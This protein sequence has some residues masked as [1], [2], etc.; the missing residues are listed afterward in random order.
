ML[1]GISVRSPCLW[2]ALVASFLLAAPLSAAEW[3]KAPDFETTKEIEGQKVRFAFK[4]EYLA[5][6][7]VDGKV[8]LDVRSD[9]GLQDFQ[10]K[11]PAILTALAERKSKGCGV[12]I[13]LPSLSPVV[14]DA[15]S[16]RIDGKVRVELRQKLL[17]K[18]KKLTRE[19]ADLVVTARPLVG[20]DHIRFEATV[21]DLNLGKS[22][23]EGMEDEVRELAQDALSK[24]ISDEKTR[25]GFPKEVA[26]LNPVFD[27]V[28]LKAGEGSEAVA[29]VTAH[30]DL[31]PEQAKSLADTFTGP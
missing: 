6:E 3:K 20:G 2:F 10:A 30:A 13:K 29:H 15:G 19:T 7:P 8:R 18:C 9:V 22:L 25:F 11:I 16:L 28:E 4:P 21:E 26:D 24:V 27:T 14:F 31:T 17:G 12:R 23:L 1:S 5:N